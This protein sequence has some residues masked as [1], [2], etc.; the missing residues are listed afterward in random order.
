MS[1]SF[2]VPLDDK[3]QKTV[4]DMLNDSFPTLC[5]Y[6]VEILSL[7]I[8]HRSCHLKYQFNTI[9]AVA[10]SI[11]STWLCCRQVRFL[12]VAVLKCLAPVCWCYVEYNIVLYYFDRLLLPME[13]YLL[14]NP[15]TLEVLFNN[16]HKFNHYLSSPES[17]TQFMA[18]CF[19]SYL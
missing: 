17:Q 13:K 18:L 4:R 9:V 15:Q 1:P 7:F 16:L 3:Y 10:Y 11:W 2:Q 5:I 6:F 12:M 8:V 14:E 19:K